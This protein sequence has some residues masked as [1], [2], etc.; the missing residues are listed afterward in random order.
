MSPNCRSKAQ[1]LRNFHKM[2][3]KTQCFENICNGYSFVLENHRHSAKKTNFEITGLARHYR[4]LAEVKT[5]FN[6]LLLLTVYHAQSLLF[7]IYV[8]G[9]VCRVSGLFPKQAVF[10]SHFRNIQSKQRKFYR[11]LDKKAFTAFLP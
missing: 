8:S 4:S 1:L 6:S 10:P 3:V 2:P 5:G 7:G 11:P 9:S